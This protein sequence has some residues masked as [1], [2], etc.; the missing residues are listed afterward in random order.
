M[1]KLSK[2]MP[3]SRRTGFEGGGGRRHD[4]GTRWPGFRC[5]SEQARPVA[6]FSGPSPLQA[7]QLS[8]VG[9]ELAMD[10]INA[11]G[12]VLGRQLALVIRDNEHKLDRGVAQTHELIPLE[13]YVAILAR[14][15]ASSAWP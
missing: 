10:Q 8:R 5:R 6:A 1:T 9:A 7:G 15:A 4:G 13:G 3:T 2:G 14:R 12:G 11:A